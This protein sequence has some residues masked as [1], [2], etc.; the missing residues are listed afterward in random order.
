MLALPNARLSE[1]WIADEPH[2]SSTQWAARVRMVGRQEPV[3]TVGARFLQD[4]TIFRSV[5]VVAIG[6]LVHHINRPLLVRRMS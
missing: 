4:R 3:P 1:I 5:G 6:I 2:F